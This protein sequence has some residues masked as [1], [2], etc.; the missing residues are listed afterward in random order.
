[1][2]IKNMIFGKE[3]HK[4]ID[5]IKKNEWRLLDG[6]HLKLVSHYP[7]FHSDLKQALNDLVMCDKKAN[8]ICNKIEND[9]KNRILK[10][11]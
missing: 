5:P 7:D 10:Q 4:E 8:G 2:N 9:I 3:A 6:K 1:M 11:T